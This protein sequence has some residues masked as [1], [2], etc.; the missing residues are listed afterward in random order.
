[1]SLKSMDFH[2]V[3][4]EIPKNAIVLSENNVNTGIVTKH[5]NIIHNAI[6]WHKIIVITH[7]NHISNF[8]I[9]HLLF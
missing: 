1:M 8:Y 2:S 9:I 6:F 4:G 5:N 3:V 7:Q